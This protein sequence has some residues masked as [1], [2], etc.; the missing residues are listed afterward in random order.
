MYI[1]FVWSFE[2]SR[3]V[4]LKRPYGHRPGDVSLGSSDGK[5]GRGR[6]VVGVAVDGWMTCDFT[7]FCN[8]TLDISGRR[9]GDIKACVQ[10]NTVSD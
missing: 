9:E 8:S 4:Y 3:I 1:Y 6:N 10:W 2:E 5:W 7:V